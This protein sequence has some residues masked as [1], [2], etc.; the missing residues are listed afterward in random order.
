MATDPETLTSVGEE[1][2]AREL[3]TIQR[4]IGFVAARHHSSVTERQ[5]FGSYV[6]LKLVE[7]DYAVLRKHQGR[8]SMRTY[9]STVIARLFLD[10]RI[11][12]W[13]KWRP[14]AAA[15]RCG[16]IGVLFEQ[17][18]SRD[19]YS[20]DEAFELLR[21]NYGLTLRR[22]DIDDLVAR[23]PQRQRRRFESDAA[24]VNMEAGPSPADEAL[25]R[26]AEHLIGDRITATLHRTL[27]SLDAEDRLLITMRFEDGCTVAEIAA[28][29]RLDQKRLY[30]RL[31]HLLDVLRASLE[32][33]GITAGAASELLQ[34]ATLALEWPET[35]STPPRAPSSRVGEKDCS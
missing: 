9:L 19:G 15:R 1:L 33:E 31:D 28:V 32:R 21:T 35:L 3:A 13:G 12:A 20:V 22:R 34:R 27:A 6:T 8:S 16:P 26:E 18:T 4:I 7:D 5:D 10:F 29:L 17:L 14:S 23:L 11:A 24:L 25:A 2:F 30:R